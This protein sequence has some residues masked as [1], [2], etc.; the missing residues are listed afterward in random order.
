LLV[1]IAACGDGDGGYEP[2]EEYA[3]SEAATSFDVTRTA[4]TKPASALVGDRL[5]G[6][7]VGNSI[8]NRNWVTAPSSTIGLDGLGPTFNATSCSA[9]HLLDGRGRPPDPGKPMLSALVRLSVLDPSGA[10]VAEP[11]YGDQFNPSSILGVPGEGLVEL[12]WTEEPGQYGDG[13]PYSLRR[14]TIGFTNLGFGAMAE[15]TMTSLRVAPQVA[16]LGLLELVAEADIVALADPDD[17]DGDGISGRPNRVFDVTA[18]VDR[19]GRFG[20]KANQP[21]IFQQS[22]GAFLGDIGITSS[23]FSQQNCPPAQGACL[24]ATDGTGDDGVEVSND[25]LARITFYGMTLAAPGR[26]HVRDP[27]VL[28]GKRLFSDIG[29]AGCHTPVLHT[30]ASTEL[31]ELAGQTIRPYTDLLIHDL[32]DDLADGRPDF[33]ADG[34]EWRTP[35]L[36]G[37]GLIKTVNG[38]DLLLH[39]GRARGVAEAIL[40][41]GGEAV[42]AREAFRALSADDRARLI[43][44]LESL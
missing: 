9:C 32:G 23:L 28:D 26:R 16:G 15:G 27:D 43:A 37:I 35:P 5:D 6:F 24:A 44:F 12:T 30:A 8:F 3:G 10:V 25:K 19:L 40:W 14:P 34:R 31:P 33:L 7:F 42:A 41:H 20:W 39:D 1:A 18:G 11:S 2:G 17:A 29:C 36:W 22:A 21:S 4:F 38:H 13:S